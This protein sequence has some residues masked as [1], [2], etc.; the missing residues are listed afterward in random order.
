MYL[1]TF[2]CYNIF[3]H[4]PCSYS[5]IGCTVTDCVLNVSSVKNVDCGILSWP[6][7]LN[8]MVYGFYCVWVLSE[9]R[10]LE[11][12]VIDVEEVRVYI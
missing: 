8:L 9:Y 12:L 2:T 3:C 4:L 7:C 1:N 11:K 10:T 6:I 5:I